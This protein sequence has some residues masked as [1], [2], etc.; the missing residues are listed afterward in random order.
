MWFLQAPV[1]QDRLHDRD[2][3]RLPLLREPQ[4]AADAARWSAALRLSPFRRRASV[5]AW[6]GHRAETADR[7]VTRII[8]TE[9]VRP[10][11]RWA[12]DDPPARV[13]CPRTDPGTRDRRTMTTRWIGTRPHRLTTAAVDAGFKATGG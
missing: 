10:F 11:F 3:G 1:S 8:P 4:P 9:P 7:R 6:L 2:Y 13:W 12:D 5:P